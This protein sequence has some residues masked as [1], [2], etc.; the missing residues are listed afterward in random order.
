MSRLKF[1]ALFLFAFSFSSLSEASSCVKTTVDF[2]QC[3]FDV[4]EMVSGDSSIIKNNDSPFF[5]GAIAAKCSNG[6]INIA[7]QVCKPIDPL[8]CSI[9][10]ASWKSDGNACAHEAQSTPLKNGGKVK[11][12][13]NVNSGHVNYQCES[14]V[15]KSKDISCETQSNKLKEIK[16]TT[17]N[18]EKTMQ[19]GTFSFVHS[20]S[21]S[22]SEISQSDILNLCIDKMVEFNIATDSASITAEGA[23]SVRVDCVIN[24]ELSCDEGYLEDTLTL[25]YHP[26]PH[27]LYGLIYAEIRQ[28]CQD[29]GYTDSIA[30]FGINPSLSS[31]GSTYADVLVKCEGKQSSCGVAPD[32]GDPR[33][34]NATSCT[35]AKVESG[36]ITIHKARSLSNELVRTSACVPLG[37]DTLVSIDNVNVERP[38]GNYEYVKVEATCGTYTKRDSEPLLAMCV[39]ENSNGSS[40]IA[41]P[42]DCNSA[43][44]V[45]TIRGRSSIVNPGTYSYP[46]DEEVRTKVCLDASYEKLDQVL[47]VE[48]EMNGYYIVEAS[49]S[50]YIGTDRKNCDGLGPC[51]GEVLPPGSQELSIDHEGVLYRDLCATKDEPSSNVCEQCKPSQVSFT[52]SSNGNTCTLTSKVADSGRNLEFDFFNSSFNGSV[53]TS[54]NNGKTTATDGTCY[55]NCPGN[56]NVGWND[57]RGNQ[58]CTQTIPSGD[59]KHGDI[60]NLNRSSVNTGSASFQCDGNTGKW[61]NKSGSCKLDCNGSASWGSGI[62]GNGQNKNG[63]CSTS[64]SNMKD[65]DI[66][67]KNSS[68]S[69]TTGSS[70]LGCS[71]GKITTSSSSCNV[72]CSS[73]SKSWGGACMAN[74]PSMSHG[75]STRISHSGNSSHPFSSTISGSATSSCND[76]AVSVNGSC[77]YVVREIRSN[78]SS[79][80]EYNRSCNSTPDAST[81]EQGSTFNQ[82]TTCSI[83]ENRSRTVKQLWNDGRQVD[84]PNESQNRTRY[85]VSEQ[86]VAGTKIPDRQKISET[87]GMWSRW[88]ETGKSYDCAVG[89]GSLTFFE[90][91]TVCKFE[92]VRSRSYYEIYSAFP[93]RVEVPSKRE[94]ETGFILKRSC[95]S[96]GGFFNQCRNG[97]KVYNP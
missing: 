29:M 38:A 19:E 92:R 10:E 91:F 35:E 32:S 88:T 16:V 12:L 36:L 60:V 8:D 84:L 66:L 51:F 13:S 46:S 65:G 62:S 56:V 58:S 83:Y 71:D 40:P 27:E 9:G 47:S 31:N 2:K 1:L 54:C 97:W 93:T 80:R 25:P 22:I 85:S 45:K 77:S 72:N 3:S 68:T 14:G 95:T 82:K 44:V 89:S 43:N 21:G 67:V 64:V 79:W 49:C 52:D 20:I 15:L 59:Y 75:N 26:G 42:V 50:G 63:L 11:I 69:G 24:R 18:V 55:K 61:V 94:T 87:Y 76:G 78:W 74:S 17:Q 48:P 4:P 33:I 96:T 90:F 41:Q 53:S 81:V 28:S 57:S 70:S 34:L 23:N 30:P 39:A 5:S 7:K 86:S 37:F 73:E 6:V